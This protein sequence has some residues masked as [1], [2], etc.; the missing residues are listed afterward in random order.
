MNMDEPTAANVT[1]HGA[2]VRVSS[3]HSIKEVLRWVRGERAAL[4]PVLD[5]SSASPR[6]RVRAGDRLDRLHTVRAGGK[7]ALVR[8]HTHTYTHMY[9]YIHIYIHTSLAHPSCTLSIS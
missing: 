2:V 3:V 4:A 7:A 5:S 9:I 8:I 1:E 6:D